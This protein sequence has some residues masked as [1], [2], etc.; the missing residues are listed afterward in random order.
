MMAVLAEE[1]NPERIKEKLMPKVLSMMA[2]LMAAPALMA[3]L[4]AARNRLAMRDLPTLPTLPTDLGPL[5]RTIPCAITGGREARHDRGCAPVPVPV[6]Q[7]PTASKP[8]ENRTG[9]SLP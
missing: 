3:S 6:H 9:A 2:S 4:M 7:E 1:A 5:G 8:L